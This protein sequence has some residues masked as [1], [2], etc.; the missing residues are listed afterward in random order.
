MGRK[1]SQKN[2]SKLS[3][4]Q[5]ASGRTELDELRKA[6]KLRRAFPVNLRDEEWA[7]EVK[8]LEGML[9]RAVMHQRASET[10]S[11]KSKGGKR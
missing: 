6:L 2:E 4:D 11:R 3:K 1:G 7:T 10:H 5:I 9:K 8:R